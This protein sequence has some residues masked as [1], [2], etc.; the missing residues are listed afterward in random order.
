[1]GTIGLLF[2]DIEGSTRLATELGSV[3][4]RVL[5][6]HHAILRGAIEENGGFIDGIEGD[7][8][9]ATFADASAAARAAVEALRGLRS[10]AWPSGVGELKV[11]MGLHVGYAQR[12]STGYQGLEVHRAA[13]V[14]A[15][16]HGGQLLLSAAARSLVGDV[17]AVEPL[18][19]HRLNDFPVAES[20]FCAVV[21][22]RGA[23]SFPPPRTEAVRP[24][25][26]PAGIPQLIGRE[27]EIRL[28]HDAFLLDGGRVVT[29][30]GRG[31]RERR[32]SRW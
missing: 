20:L 30:T 23:A 3:W 12:S 28:V 15:A 29:V 19:L 5:K 11:R 32:A 31:G 22:G 21:G 17:V 1:V 16:A 4:P 8:F 10:Y 14:A 7:A 25:N 9:F 2:T 24:T 6:E 26:L 18:G 13:R 27:A